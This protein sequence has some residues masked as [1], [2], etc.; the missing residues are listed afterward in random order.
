MLPMAIE[1]GLSPSLIGRIALGKNAVEHE[2]GFPTG[3]KD[4]V[5][6]DG[7]SSSF[8]NDVGVFF[9]D[10]DDLLVGGHFLPFEQSSITLVDDSMHQC[11]KV[12]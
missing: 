9:K 10:G 4:L 8:A 6:E 12:L 2:R 11:G 1:H 7:L 3:K 5:S